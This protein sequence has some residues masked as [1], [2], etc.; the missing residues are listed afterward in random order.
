MSRT[1]TTMTVRLSGTLWDFVAHNV[2]EDGAYD[3]SGRNI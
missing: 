3:T 2:S 1:T